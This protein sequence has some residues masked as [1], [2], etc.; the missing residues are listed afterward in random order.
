MLRHIIL[1]RPI[2][3]THMN[4][5]TRCQATGCSTA[6]SGCTWSAGLQLIFPPCKQCM[7]PLQALLHVHSGGRRQLLI[8]TSQIAPAY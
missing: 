8:L 1:R 4:T 5:L 2:N 3:C 6:I 7:G